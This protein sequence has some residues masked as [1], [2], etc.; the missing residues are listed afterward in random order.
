M[1]FDPGTTTTRKDRH[2]LD[3]CA[4]SG[5][6]E[7][8]HRPSCPNP[9][10]AATPDGTAAHTLPS[11]FRSFF[12]TTEYIVHRSLSRISVLLLVL[13][14]PERDETL[15]VDNVRNRSPITTV[16]IG[17]EGGSAGGRWADQ[18]NANATHHRRCPA[19][20][21]T[22]VFSCLFLTCSP[23]WAVRRCTLSLFHGSQ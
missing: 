21:R 22:L 9:T 23:R 18:T 3:K 14:N 10:C 1:C 15:V 12:T 6:S 11:S 5:G 17:C 2:E 7:N 13:Q 20:N 19:P 4:Y 8:T 16:L